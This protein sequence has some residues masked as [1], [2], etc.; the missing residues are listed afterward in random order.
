MQWPWTKKR[1]E[2]IAETPPAPKADPF[3]NPVH[4]EYEI[5]VIERRWARRCAYGTG[6]AQELR[7]HVGNA[8]PVKDVQELLAWLKWRLIDAFAEGDGGRQ[9]AAKE[10]GVQ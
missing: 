4:V 5:V 7:Y 3:E 6:F 2:A 1:G 8:S 10:E 9:A